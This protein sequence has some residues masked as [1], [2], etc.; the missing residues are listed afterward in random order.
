MK[1]ILCPVDFSKN[2]ENAVRYAGE[3]ASAL[4]SNV[5]LMHAYE[6]PVIYTDVTVPAVVPDLRMFYDTAL[7]ELKK[8]HAKISREYPA[9]KFEMILQQGLPSARTL[10]IAIE[11]KVDLI[12]MASSSTTGFEKV[13]LGSNANRVMKDADCM[14]MIIPPK[15]KYKG[16]G[17]IV[18][19]TDLS[20]ENLKSSNKLIPLASTLRS[21]IIYLN[22]DN[23]NLMHDSEDLDRIT[24]RVKQFVKYPKMQGYVCTDLN[25]A[26]GITYFLKQKKADCLC[27]VTHHR[28]F[29]QSLINPSV[30]KRV[31]YRTDLPLLVIH[32][33]D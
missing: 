5:I 3:L 14:V 26:D 12:V 1:R 7:S 32:R 27:M 16:L 31:A 8:F 24:R 10:E 28:K 2:S 21:E 18:F 22:I 19:A 11:K 13:L 20:E 29:F 15:S 4:N 17:N 30:T 6:T 33:E 23:K 25:I 9:I